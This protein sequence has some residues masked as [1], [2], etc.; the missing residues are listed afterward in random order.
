MIK[1]IS[2]LRT[3]VDDVVHKLKEHKLKV[4]EKEEARKELKEKALALVRRIQVEKNKVDNLEHE[5]RA[6]KKES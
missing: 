5:N 2:D 6:L 3:L 4:H 1:K